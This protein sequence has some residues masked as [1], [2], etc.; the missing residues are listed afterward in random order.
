MISRCS[1]KQAVFTLRGG[2]HHNDVTPGR[3]ATHSALLHTSPESCIDL[4]CGQRSLT[5]G[6]YPQY[7][8]LARQ[9][10]PAVPPATGSLVRTPSTGRVE[11]F[12]ICLCGCWFRIHVRLEG[13][14]VTIAIRNSCFNCHFQSLHISINR[15]MEWPKMTHKLP[16]SQAPL[17]TI[18]E[19]LLLKDS[20]FN[21]R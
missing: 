18:H 4:L 21:E 13:S 2:W 19:T 9:E 16:P 7:S 10:A 6:P 11:Y 1:V 3:D 14:Y 15:H 12:R 17:S 20:I 8:L 5:A